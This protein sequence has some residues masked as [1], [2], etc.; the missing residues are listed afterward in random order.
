MVRWPVAAF[1]GNSAGRFA[2]SKIDRDMFSDLPV[3]M[4]KRD[5]QARL[6]LCA[7]NMAEN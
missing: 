2:G 5:G 3:A 6:G 1:I 7:A 4:V